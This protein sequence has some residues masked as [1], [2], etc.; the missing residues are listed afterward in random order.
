MTAQKMGWGKDVL[1]R[2]NSKSIGPEAGVL[3][4]PEGIP[5]LEKG[6]AFGVEETN[7]RLIGS[8]QILRKSAF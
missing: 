1:G 6:L 5:G 3:Q 4:A 7:V 2:A 8:P